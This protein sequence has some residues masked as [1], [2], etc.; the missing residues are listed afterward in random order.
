M[1]VLLER[2][3]ER[4]GILEFDDLLLTRARDER[5]YNDM[6]LDRRTN[7][8]VFLN[9]GKNIPS[10]IINIFQLLLLKMISTENLIPMIRTDVFSEFLPWSVVNVR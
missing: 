3:R 5:I 2:E 6:K 7:D 9:L 1:F 4:A 10:R 8:S